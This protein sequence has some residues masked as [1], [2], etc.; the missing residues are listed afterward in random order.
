MIGHVLPAQ[1]VLFLVVF[2]LVIWSHQL[3]FWTFEVQIWQLTNQRLKLLF[4][5]IIILYYYFL[6]L[7]IIIIL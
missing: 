2:A 6:L 4:L 5:D 7:F 1:S 3:P